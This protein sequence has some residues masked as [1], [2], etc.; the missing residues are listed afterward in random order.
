MAVAKKTSSYYYY[1]SKSSLALAVSKLQLLLEVL[2]LPS[3]VQLNFIL[4]RYSC[5]RVFI[6][7]AKLFALGEQ[8]FFKKKNDNLHEWK[9]VLVEFQVSY[10]QVLQMQLQFYRSQITINISLFLRSTSQQYSNI[11]LL[12]A[13][14][15]Y[16][17]TAN[18]TPVATANS[19]IK[20]YMDA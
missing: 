4:T 20:F 13:V 19:S 3:S 18:S 9:S 11:F 2:L 17:A 12:P 8:L 6:S 16:T 10:P 14:Q 15:Q 1:Y 7:T 5:G